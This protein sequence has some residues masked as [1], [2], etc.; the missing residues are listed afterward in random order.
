MK[1]LFLL[2]VFLLLLFSCKKNEVRHVPLDP[3]VKATFDW[4]EGSYWVMQDSATGQIDSFYVWYY[5][6]WY[7]LSSEDKNFEF[8]TVAINVVNTSDISDSLEMQIGLASDYNR[9]TIEFNLGKSSD[10]SDSTFGINGFFPCPKE[11]SD[12]SYT[13]NGEKFEHV[14]L[15]STDFGHYP[16][17]PKNNLSLAVNLERGILFLACKGS[18]YRHTWY[19]LRHTI[20]RKP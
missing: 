14:Y 8:L 19:L 10:L 11:Y 18:I 13:I 20:V 2:P 3:L 1:N 4:H 5:R 9:S 15:N 16:V 12:V 6:N 7:S 17:V